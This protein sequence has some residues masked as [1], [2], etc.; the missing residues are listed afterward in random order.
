MDKE[1]ELKP[2]DSDVRRDYAHYV[3]RQRLDDV[4]VRQKDAIRKLYMPYTV[5]A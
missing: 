3:Y 1:N 2:R 5:N 4:N